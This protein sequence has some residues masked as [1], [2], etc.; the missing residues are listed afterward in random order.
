MADSEPD[1]IRLTNEAPIPQQDFW[2]L[3][4]P[5]LRH[6]PRVRAVMDFMVRVMKEKEDLV[7]GHKPQRK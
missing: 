3:T 2:V 7:I 5:D 4:H 1:L 6:T